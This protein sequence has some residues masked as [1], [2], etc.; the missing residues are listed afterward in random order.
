MMDDFNE[1]NLYEILGVDTDASTE[2]IK[3]KYHSL[4]KFYHPDKN[5]GH[6]AVVVFEKIQHAYSILKDVDLKN[7]YDEQLLSEDPNISDEVDINDMN[8]VGDSFEYD[9]RCG[10]KYIIL[11]DDLSQG[12]DTVQ[13]S[14]CSLLIKVLFEYDSEEEEEEE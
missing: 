5:K 13:C 9:C 1:K 14:G 10:Y 11:E 12:Y 4:A 7:K 6:S 2:E 3:Q 8:F